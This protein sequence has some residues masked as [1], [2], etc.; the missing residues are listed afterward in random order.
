M[1]RALRACKHPALRRSPYPRPS[2]MKLTRT[3]VR[4][5]LGCTLQ[6]YPTCIDI[7]PLD[8]SSSYLLYSSY[9][10]DMSRSLKVKAVVQY[11]HKSQV[12]TSVCR[13]FDSYKNRT[14][15]GMQI[16]GMLRRPTN[17]IASVRSGGSE[18]VNGP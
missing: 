13:L 3:R 8:L 6:K 10:H 11:M 12:F 15:S 18:N 7:S 5:S 17:C 1:V 4:G 2:S 16:C 9:L 14:Q